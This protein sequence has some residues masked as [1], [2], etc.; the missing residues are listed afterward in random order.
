MEPALI[1]KCFWLQVAGAQPIKVNKG[2]GGVAGLS[3]RCNQL[4]QSI[5]QNLFIMVQKC[6]S[7]RGES[8]HDMQLMMQTFWAS[9]ISLFLL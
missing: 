1:V 9:L 6:N 8:L 4:D 5:Y 3:D 7:Q 2:G